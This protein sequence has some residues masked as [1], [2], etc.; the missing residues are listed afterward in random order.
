MSYIQAFRV[1]P[2]L[3]PDD[4]TLIAIGQDE[5]KTLDLNLDFDALA[6]AAALLGEVDDLGEGDVIVIRKVAY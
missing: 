2:E 6:F 3:A 5:P 1:T 4:T